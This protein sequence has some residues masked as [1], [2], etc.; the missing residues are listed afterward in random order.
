MPLECCFRGA[1]EL[2]Y[3]LNSNDYA[4]LFGHA[5]YADGMLPSHCCHGGGSL[6]GM[7]NTQKVCDSLLA[8]RE[9]GHVFGGLALVA[10]DTRIELGAST[11]QKQQ[12]SC[13][14]VLP[15]RGAS[16]LIV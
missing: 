10:E 6:I 15:T 2:N 7:I 4:T 16:I 13:A 1:Y 11:V 8:R 12:P 3:R 5:D 9:D 14:T